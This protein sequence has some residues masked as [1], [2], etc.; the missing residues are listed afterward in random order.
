MRR[1]LL[2]TMLF[3]AV[4]GLQAC[5][6]VPTARGPMGDPLGAIAS[7]PTV[8][9]GSV[10]VSIQVPAPTAA[11]AVDSSNL[12]SAETFEVTISRNGQVLDQQ[13]LYSDD[14]RR[15]R[16]RTSF[17]ALEPGPAVITV[18]AYDSD[19]LLVGMGSRPIEIAPYRKVSTSLTVKPA[20]PDDETGDPLQPAPPAVATPL[21]T[22]APS[23]TSMFPD[24]DR[25][26]ISQ[27]YD[28]KWNPSAPSWTQNC[29]PACLAMT[30]EAFRI[31][32]PN[33]TQFGD[34]EDVIHKTRLAMM[35]TADDFKLASLEDIE[36]GADACGLVHTRANGLDEIERQVAMGHLVIVAGDPIAY[37]G[38]FTAQQYSSFD[39][40][41]FVLLTGVDGSHAYLND[42]L[43]HQGNI[44]VTTDEFSRYM[45]Y[46]NWNVGIALSRRETFFNLPTP[47][48]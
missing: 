48:I 38:R 33:L 13:S 11:A 37:C 7:R 42:P 29:G 35:G 2:Q 39:G 22:P 4:L 21:P 44:P 43:S 15:G 5:V 31:L 17:S 41:H 3:S 32:P 36:H 9:A 47:Q 26:F 6:I 34:P 16:A 1:R 40:G 18:K 27:M 8:P 25:F 23:P 46:Q 14:F 30:L 28:S 12:E 19:S 10:A 24:P 45:A 20:T